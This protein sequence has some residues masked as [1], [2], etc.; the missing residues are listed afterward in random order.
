[1]ALFFGYDP[2]GRRENGRDKPKNGVAALE[3][4]RFGVFRVLRTSSLLDASEVLSWFRAGPFAVA[5]GVDTL[6]AWSFRGRRACDDRLK[7]FY[8]KRLGETKAGSVQQQNSLHSAMTINGALVAYK[9][10]HDFGLPLVESH[11]KLLRVAATCR[12]CPVLPRHVTETYEELCKAEPGDHDHQADA[13]IAAWC[14]SRWYFRDRDWKTDLYGV[15][16]E[17]PLFFPAGPAVYPWPED[18]TQGPD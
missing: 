13:F 17:D 16:P 4:D 10:C 18:I 12:G 6:L 8:A 9:V 3:V 15:D 5:L 2:G 14:A 1:M 7:D 11:P